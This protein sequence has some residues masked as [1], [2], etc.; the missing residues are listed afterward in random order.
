MRQAFGCQRCYGE[1]P[2]EVWAYYERGLLIEREL[3]D[4]P[5][6]VV[7]LRRCAEC[8]QE[9]VWIL[10]ERVDWEGGE[11]AQHR[12]VV[13][14][15]ADEAQ[16]LAIDLRSLTELGRDRRYLETDWPQG[17]GERAVQWTSGV[18]VILPG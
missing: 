14:V 11:D 6:F 18:L 10:T 16:A 3:V 12:N 5:H 4:D 17:A 9:F 2:D 15:S 8:A 7:Q 13:P 1:D